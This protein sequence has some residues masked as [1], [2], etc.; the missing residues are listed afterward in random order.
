MANNYTKFA[1][2]VSLSDEEAGWCV[3]NID[4]YADHADDEVLDKYGGG[5]DY[6]F[7][8]EGLT[9]YLYS[10]EDGSVDAVVAFVQAFLAKF[11][12]D[13]KFSIQWAEVCS[14]PRPG[15]FGGGAAVVSATQIKSMTTL[16][17][18]ADKMKG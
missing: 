18:V 4:D 13:K 15:E 17:W 3:T 10:E 14:N 6:A 11:R 16:Q 5:F 12:P 8:D 9:L 7:E 1:E 2:A